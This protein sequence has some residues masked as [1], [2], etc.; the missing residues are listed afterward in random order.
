MSCQRN[1]VK[2]SLS[3]G[4]LQNAVAEFRVMTN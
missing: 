1:V 3:I 4:Q 2:I